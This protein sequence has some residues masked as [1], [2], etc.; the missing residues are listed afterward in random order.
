MTVIAIKESRTRLE[1]VFA[2][3]YGLSLPEPGRAAFAAEHGLVWSGPE[4][5]LL[6]CSAREGLAGLSQRLHGIAA[7]TDQSDAYGVVAIS[8][9]KARDMLAKGV[10]IDL[11][12]N[13]FGSGSAAR[14]AIAHLGVQL[15]QRTD[16]PAYELTVARS[17]AGSL[18]SW[19]LAASA[20][21]GAET[22]ACNA[23]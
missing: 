1:R 6:T 16:E 14:T 8:G 5:W 21:F 17:F 3:R 10:A 12:P 9:P 4:Q 11:H 7:V 13:G 23:A 18:W 22:L 19:L 2:D 15:W 20:E